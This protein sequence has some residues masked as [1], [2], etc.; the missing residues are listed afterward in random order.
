MLIGV[1]LLFVSARKWRQ[2]HNTTGRS[3]TPKAVTRQLES[4][5]PRKAGVLGLLIQ[6]RSL[7]IA[8]A[9]V[10]SRDRTGPFSYLGG[11][12]VF[13]LLSTAALVA[14]FA[15]YL[16]RPDRATKQFGILVARIQNASPTILPLLCGLGGIYLL[17]DAARGLIT[18]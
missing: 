17:I 14:L 6:P 12:G 18:A 15:Y 1:V 11:L 2:R 10:V 3:V 7:T 5:S 4:L 16:R 8:A 9:I 13:A